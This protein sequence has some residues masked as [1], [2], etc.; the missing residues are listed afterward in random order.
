[1]IPEWKIALE[2][3]IAEMY[4]AVPDWVREDLFAA[5]EWAKKTLTDHEGTGHHFNLVADADRTM[6]CCFAKPQW[7]ADHCGDPMDSGSEAIVRAVCEYLCG[8]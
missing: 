5:M 6:V 7:N 4:E 3:R 1:M 8:G 2:A